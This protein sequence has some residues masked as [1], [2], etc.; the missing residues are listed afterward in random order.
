MRRSPGNLAV[1]I[2]LLVILVPMTAA[3]AEPV[4]SARGEAQMHVDRGLALYEAKE[5]A[6]AAA[7]LETAYALGQQRDVLYALAQARR[8]AG[9]CRGAVPLYRKFL[10]ANPPAREADLARKNVS[11]CDDAKSDRDA[12]VA[13]P[14]TPSPSAPVAPAPSPPPTP[15]PTTAAEAP[16]HSAEHAEPPKSP[17]VAWYRDVPG[18][19]LLGAAAVG[20]GVS[21]FFYFASRSEV[22]TARSA[23]RY[24]D[25]Q[26]HAQRAE[27]DRTVALIGGAAGGALLVSAVLRFVLRDKT[28]TNRPT[29]TAAIGAASSEVLVRF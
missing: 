22:Q 25:A 10:D 8:L 7:E 18:D 21:G 5:Y 23:S 9:D 26:A 27:R 3:R 17:T 4:G 16:P 28:P 20:A 1:R 13:A 19:V 2:A 11:R 15:A 14:A 12:H 6:A 29:V 24:D